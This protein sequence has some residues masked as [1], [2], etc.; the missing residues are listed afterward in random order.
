M[1]GIRVLAA[2]LD[3]IFELT[4]DVTRDLTEKV[5]AEQLLNRPQLVVNH[6][7]RLANVGLQRLDV[8]EEVL[9]PASIVRH[10]AKNILHDVHPVSE[11]DGTDLS[12]IC[13]LYMFLNFHRSHAGDR[14]IIF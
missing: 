5:I 12:F 13:V 10:Q 14:A 6:V 7:I 1:V 2:E 4:V 3:L 8:I 9:G 11:I